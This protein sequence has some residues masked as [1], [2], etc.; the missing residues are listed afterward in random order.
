MAL[1]WTWNPGMPSYRKGGRLIDEGFENDGEVIAIAKRNR[2]S[3]RKDVRTKSIGFFLSPRKSNAKG[4]PKKGFPKK[5]IPKS[6]TLAGTEGGYSL[7]IPSPPATVE[8]ITVVPR[9]SDLFQLSW[10]KMN[11]CTGKSIKILQTFETHVIKEIKGSSTSPDIKLN[12]G[13]GV[14]DLKLSSSRSSEFKGE[15]SKIQSKSS[16]SANRKDDYVKIP[17]SVRAPEIYISIYTD[18]ELICESIPVY[19]GH[20]YR[21][22]A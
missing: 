2:E 7:P 17:A 13:K 8:Q 15:F 6:G 16:V 19:R 3:E 12:T 22:T 10:F 20:S 21:V 4:P 5:G 9:P 11:N 14:L 1:A 18:S